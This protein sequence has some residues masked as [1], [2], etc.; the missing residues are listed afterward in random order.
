M[1]MG[2]GKRVL[3]FVCIALGT[4]SVADCQ[5][6]TDFLHVGDAADGGGT[7]CALADY[8][9]RLS[10][11][12]AACCAAP[13]SPCDADGP[14]VCT[15]ACA[16]TL[17]DFSRDCN[18]T[19]NLLLDAMDGNHDGVVRQTKRLQDACDVIPAVDI[20]GELSRLQDEE[21][22]AV[23]TDGVAETSVS[24]SS[25]GSACGDDTSSDRCN[26]LLGMGF[27]CDRDFCPTCTHA[28][29]C[30]TTCGFCSTGDIDQSGHRRA[31]INLDATCTTATLATRVEQVNQACCDNGACEATTTFSSGVP[32]RCDA[33][34]AMV[35]EYP[36]KAAHP[37]LVVPFAGL[38]N[39]STSLGVGLVS[40]MGRSTARAATHCGSRA[41]RHNTSM[42]S[43]LLRERVTAYRWGHC[44]TQQRDATYLAHRLRRRHHRHLRP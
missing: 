17:R 26:S 13:E 33:R 5:W 27:S 43:P 29:E 16:A 10:Q 36:Q 28:S 7:A 14:A 32:T 44:L 8:R 4:I 22:C 3:S 41:Y 25:D 9:L 12:D 39:A 6:L 34:C 40:Q 31:Q 37:L 23:Q 2:D 21:G 15:I 20:V 19:S 30:D 1:H 35:C 11:V 24:S 18:A 38:T 42:T